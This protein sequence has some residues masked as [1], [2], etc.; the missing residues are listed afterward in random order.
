MH[1]SLSTNSIRSIIEESGIEKPSLRAV[2][3]VTVH[4]DSQCGERLW[5]LR[6]TPEHIV[7]AASQCKGLEGEASYRTFAQALKQ[8]KLARA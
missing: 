5:E 4:V 8:I 3:M 2:E 7:A 6:F 1:K